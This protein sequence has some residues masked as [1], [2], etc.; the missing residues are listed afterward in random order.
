MATLDDWMKFVDAPEIDAP[1][2]LYE[3]VDL[4]A[5][6]QRISAA[7]EQDRVCET[8]ARLPPDLKLEFT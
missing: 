1:A 5:R 2:P 8:H 4:D 6:L 3:S 7:L